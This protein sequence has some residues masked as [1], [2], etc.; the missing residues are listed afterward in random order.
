MGQKGKVF[1]YRLMAVNTMEEEISEKSLSK[2]LN[3]KMLFD[4]DDKEVSDSILCK[5]D[6]D[7][8]EDLFFQFGSP[9][10]QN[11]QGLYRHTV[12]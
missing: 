5:V 7:D 3:A 10:R 12:L 2:E 11:L 9:L 4:L 1:A 6:V 8:C